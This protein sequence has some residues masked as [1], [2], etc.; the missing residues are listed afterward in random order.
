LFDKTLITSQ[1]ALENG[2]IDEIGTIDDI[3]D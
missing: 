1:E 2:L 3:R